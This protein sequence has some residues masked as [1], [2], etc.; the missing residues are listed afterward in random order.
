VAESELSGAPA[1][2]APARLRSVDV[3]RALVIF[4]M[5]VVNNVGEA[6]GVPWWTQ[7]LTAEVDG[8]SLADMVLPWFLFLVGVS[9]PLSLSRYVDSNQRL[10]ALG[11]VLPRAAGLLLLGLIFVNTERFDAAATGF[12]SKLWLT[13]SVAA[14]TAL[15][16]QPYPEATIGRRRRLVLGIKLGAAALLLAML[17]TYRGNREDGGSAWLVPSWWGILGIIGWAY[18]V[19]ALAYLA[20]R[21]QLAVLV[22]LLGLAVAVAIGTARGRAGLLLP[23]DSLFGVHEFFGSMTAMV[24][25]GAVA[26]LL[27]TAPGPRRWW[28]LVLLGAGL[29]SAGWFLR[30][31]HGYHKLGSSESWALVGAGQGTL[32]LALAH[33]LFD[34]L[35][36]NQRWVGAVAMAGQSALLAYLL[37]EWLHPATGL[38]GLDLTPG[39]EKGGWIAMGNAAVVAVGVLVVAGLA[40]WRRFTIKL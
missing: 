29:W 12:S 9:L 28:P 34:K 36:V 33:L 21:G 19:A 31:L 13:L 38:I 16:W 5:V 2:A 39:Y 40:T 25:A 6:P 32:M 17:L 24:L 35:L 14:A 27:L 4:V 15:L 1:P 11:R 23:F 30:P 7:H 20:A 3:L 8:Y 37:S 10:R 22:G 26:G 18:L